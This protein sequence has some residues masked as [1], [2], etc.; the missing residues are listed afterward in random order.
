MCF[1]VLGFGWTRI[2]EAAGPSPSPGHHGGGFSREQQLVV[3]RCRVAYCFSQS[4]CALKIIIKYSQSLHAI[5][6]FCFQF[7]VA[8]LT[9]SFLVFFRWNER[10]V[11][12]QVVPAVSLWQGLA[13][14]FCFVEAATLKKQIL[15]CFGCVHVLHAPAP[16]IGVPA[17]LLEMLKDRENLS[18]EG[19]N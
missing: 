2:G 13:V 19:F 17:S 9:C 10:I 8:D 11:R 5:C 1:K 6:T 3:S 16:S 18:S 4:F 14:S 15:I 7:L 12:A